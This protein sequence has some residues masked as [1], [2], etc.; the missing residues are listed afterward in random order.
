MLSLH[1]AELLD[2]ELSAFTG[3]EANLLWQLEELD[4]PADHL[5]L[6]ELNTVC[7]RLAQAVR[8]DV[9][10]LSSDIEDGNDD[11]GGD[12]EEQPAMTFIEKVWE[13][14]PIDWLTLDIRLEPPSY[15]KTERH[16]VHPELGPQIETVFDGRFSGFI[17]LEGYGVFKDDKSRAI[18]LTPKLV[19]HPFWQLS[20]LKHRA[21]SKRQGG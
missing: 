1:W 4:I 18:S 14:L 11:H 8:A 2:G 6:V 3:V 12:G 13:P 16:Y 7:L 20:A 21:S 19:T 5:A 9:F 15:G 17:G 10:R